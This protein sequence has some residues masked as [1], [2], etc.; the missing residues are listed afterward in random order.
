MAQSFSFAS[1]NKEFLFELPE[2]LWNPD[3]FMNK[4]DAKEKY[5]DDVIPIIAF[6]VNAVKSEKAFST[7]CGW[8]ATEEEIINVP[9]FQIAELKAMMADM[10]AVRLCRADHMGATIIEY[11]CKYG[12]RLKFKW[13]DR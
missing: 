1:F 2:G 5:G 10:N 9:E 7:E 4:D 8:I 3:N 13:C 12:T 6:G 11:E